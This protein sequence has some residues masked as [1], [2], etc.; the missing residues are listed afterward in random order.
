[1]LLVDSISF[2]LCPPIS[3]Q[4]ILK[5]TSKQL[6]NPDARQVF[7]GSLSQNLGQAGY[8]DVAVVDYNSNEFVVKLLK[9][10]KLP[11]LKSVYEIVGG[12]TWQDSSIA[13][14]VTFTEPVPR[15]G[16]RNDNVLGNIIALT[17]V[18]KFP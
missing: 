7:F 16:K 1:M 5:I 12:Q 3:C 9:W 13:N 15:N 6:K 8:L 18:C 10:K 2:R 14:E 17:R 11:R 4:F